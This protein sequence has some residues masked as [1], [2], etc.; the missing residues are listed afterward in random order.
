MQDFGDEAKPVVY[1]EGKSKGLVLNKT[2]ANTV[3]DA[4][5]D[6][7]E[8]WEGKETV[9]YEA[10]VEYQGRRMPGIRCIVPSQ[11]SRKSRPTKLARMM[12][13]RFER[14]HEQAMR[15]QRSV[16]DLKELTMIP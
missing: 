10:E 1:F 7:T 16:A 14:Q 3:S 8:L 11:R 12:T 9:L 4:Y 15:L 6:E 13:S 5:G 2:N